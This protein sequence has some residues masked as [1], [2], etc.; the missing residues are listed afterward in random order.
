MGVLVSTRPPPL[1]PHVLTFTLHNAVFDQ[2]QLIPGDAGWD[3]LPVSDPLRLSLMY[4]NTLN[5]NFQNMYQ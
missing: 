5:F 2:F 4:L 3:L 1:F